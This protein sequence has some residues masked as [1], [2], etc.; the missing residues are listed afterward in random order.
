LEEENNADVDAFFASESLP[1]SDDDYNDDEEEE[2]EEEDDE[3]E[4]DE[5]E[6]TFLFD[7]STKSKARAVAMASQPLWSRVVRP[8]IKRRG[9]VVIE[10]CE[11]NGKLEKRTVAKSHG[12]VFGIGRDGYRRA[13]KTKLGDLFS[14]EDVKKR[15][16]IDTDDDFDIDGTKNTIINNRA[17][18]VFDEEKFIMDWLEQKKKVVE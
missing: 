17:G 16:T 4:E 5:D 7:E 15:T 14:F 1:S 2:E 13:R 6:D 18:V 10:T 12:T 3:S 8:P 11:P 9:H